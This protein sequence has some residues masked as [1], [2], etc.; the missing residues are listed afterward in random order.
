MELPDRKS[1][2]PGAIQ[3]GELL[4]F[5][6]LAAR[7][8]SCRVLMNLWLSLATDLRLIGD[9]ELMSLTPPSKLLTSPETDSD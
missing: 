4:F 5:F 7:S 3:P 2:P 1:L 6:F 9:A 8:I